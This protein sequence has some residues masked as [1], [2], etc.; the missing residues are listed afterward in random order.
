VLELEE[1]RGGSTIRALQSLRAEA[2]ERYESARARHGIAGITTGLA[3]LDRML[4]GLQ[5]TNLYTIAARPA[6]GKTGLVTGIGKSAAASG[7]AV[8]IFS[9]EMAAVQIYMRSAASQ[10]R[11]DLS[12]IISGQEDVQAIL[13]AMDGLEGLPIYIVDTAG[14]SIAQIR[15]LSRIAKRRHKIGLVMI[16]YLGLVTAP[17]SPTREREIAAI[18]AGS[19]QLAKELDIPVVALSQLNRASEARAEKRPQLSDMR[20]SGSV[21]QDSDVVIFPYRPEYYGLTM[22]EDGRSTVGIA[23]LIVAK[24]R[25]GPTGSVR[26]GFHAESA[27]FYDLIERDDAPTSMPSRAPGW[28]NAQPEAF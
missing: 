14:L 25:N 2:I 27:S 10:G 8:L 15:T 12:R 17:G 28:W 11:L 5:R 20:D 26:C 19:K 7:E 23:E 4:S 9:L 24:Q 18:S 13:R 1:R 3:G 21:E 22:D 16:D 6:M